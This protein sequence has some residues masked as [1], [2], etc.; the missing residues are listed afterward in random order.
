MAIQPI[1]L[2]TMYSSLEK[3]S[4]LTAS[5]QQEMQ[6]QSSIQQEENAKK[7]QAKATTVEKPDMDDEGPTHI[8]DQNKGSDENTSHAEKEQQ[9]EEEEIKEPMQVITDPSLGQHIDISG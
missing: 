5:K 2:Q 3:V 6:L 1:D 4:K 9:K 7:I 8:K